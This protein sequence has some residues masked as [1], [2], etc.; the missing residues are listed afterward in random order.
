M[1]IAL[2]ATDVAIVAA[3]LILLIRVTKGIGKTRLMMEKLAAK[4]DLVV[5][6]GEPLHPDKRWLSFLKTPTHV[7]GQRNGRNVRIYSVT[8][9]SG[10]SKQT[11]AVL[12][13]R[14]SK[15]VAFEVNLATRNW[16]TGLCFW[17]KPVK[18]DDPLFDQQFILTGNKPEIAAAILLPEL[19]KAQS[20]LWHTHNCKGSITISGNVVHYEER[21]FIDNDKQV[22]RFIALAD[23]CIALADSTDAAAEMTG[24]VTLDYP[25]SAF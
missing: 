24:Q 6:G 14:L 15:T 23:F 21:G 16:A 22:L 1:I 10:K 13:V 20:T 11:F 7:E 4:L 25:P 18:T 12:D 8:R 3:V 19:R 9:G 2:V 5:T 17:K